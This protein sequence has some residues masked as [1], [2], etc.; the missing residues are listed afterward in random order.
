M[1]TVMSE[2]ATIA[3]SRVKAR[4]GC[5]RCKQRKIK[6][7]E[8]RPHC[9]Q[10]TRRQY[11]CPGY[12]RPLKWS[13]K[14]EIVRAG[15]GQAKRSKRGSLSDCVSG[16]RERLLQGDPSATGVSETEY[17]S[18]P[19]A[20]VTAQAEALSLESAASCTG[21]ITSF[22]YA[23]VPDSNFHTIN[24]D[25]D[26]STGPFQDCFTGGF[27]QWP[28]LTTLPEP[29]LE[30]DDTRISRHYFSE[31]CHINSCFDSHRNHFRVEV[32]SMMS[33]HPLIYHCILSMS[34]A[35]LATKRRDLVTTALDHRT[36]AIS[37]LTEEITKAKTTGNDRSPAS[38]SD[39]K[40]L[41]ASI[42]L[43][44]T[45][46]WH[47]PSSLGITHL[48]GARV[49]FKRWLSRT[50]E[51][52]NSSSAYASRVNSFMVGIMAYWEAV[53]SFV[54]HQ[55]LDTLSYLDGFSDQS[56]ISCIYPNPWSGICTPMFISLAKAGTLSRQRSFLR[57]LSLTGASRHLR[58]ELHADLVTQARETEK[59]VQGYRI[60][61][62]AQIGGTDDE[63]TPVAHLQQIAQIY[64][65]STLVEL[66]RVFPELLGKGAHTSRV[67][68]QVIALATGTLTLIQSLPFT[69]GVNCLFTIPLLIAGSTLQPQTRA[70]GGVDES[71][72]WG[73]IGTELLAICGQEQVCLHWRA[74]ARE[75]LRAVYDYVGMGAVCCALEILERVWQRADTA[76][77]IGAVEFVQWTDVMT[78]ERLEALFG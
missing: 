23:E 9:N 40:V 72:V 32:G 16:N 64:R 62:Q 45:E 30:D 8:T 35:H 50:P 43:G 77:E 57:R 18:L 33:T 55:P 24:T 61:C 20:P 78:E 6:C 10:C 31:V 63:R 38:D 41:L 1:T 5:L 34:A 53:S 11:E 68:D 46:G 51:L 19:T 44:T 25:V 26:T 75:R 21:D 48:H 39:L 73:N 36:R 76:S 49:L 54:T 58:D 66:Y 17:P 60:P 37:C 7:D 59:F 3:P 29:P 67:S 52:S 71:P 14:Y 74:V 4:S 28:D 2:K 69:S 42:L 12:K 47:T 27:T 15:D 22:V 13:S 65:L 56:G 70:D